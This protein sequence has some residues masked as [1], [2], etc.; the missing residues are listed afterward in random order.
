M[1]KTWEQMTD[2]EKIQDLRNDI[3]RLFKVVSDISFL[4]SEAFHRAD[5]KASEVA[6]EIE[7]LKKKM[8]QQERP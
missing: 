1:P 4:H 7:N 6:K 8:G 3:K 5:Q 2:A